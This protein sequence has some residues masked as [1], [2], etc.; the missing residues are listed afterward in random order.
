[1]GLFLGYFEKGQIYMKLIKMKNGFVNANMI[2]SFEIL[3]YESWYDIVAYSP[4]YGGD[5]ESY[6]LG[7]CAEENKVYRKLKAYQRLRALVEWLT[8]GE[9][10]IFDVMHIWESDNDD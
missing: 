7:Q 3:E 9:S 4:S 1:M 10:G 6:V 2:E 5:C 8:N